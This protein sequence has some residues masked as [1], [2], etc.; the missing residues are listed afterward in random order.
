M[1]LEE[2]RKAAMEEELCRLYEEL[3]KAYYEGGFEDPLPQLLPFFDKITKIKN[4][5]KVQNL[6]VQGGIKFCAKCG[7]K[8]ESGAKFC[9]VCGTPIQ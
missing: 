7:S 3:G 1:R 4:Q 5:Q 2:T 8:L 6:E 9:A